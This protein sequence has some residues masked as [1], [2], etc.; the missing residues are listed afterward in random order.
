MSRAKSRT[1][2]AASAASAA[3]GWR[4]LGAEIQGHI[5]RSLRPP[6]VGWLQTEALPS[7]AWGDVTCQFLI[8]PGGA[9]IVPIEAVSRRGSPAEPRGF[10]ARLIGVQTV[11]ESKRRQLAEHPAPCRSER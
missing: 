11:R 9:R 4:R 2:R 10:P 5:E 1:R 7:I 3:L 8:V 6:V